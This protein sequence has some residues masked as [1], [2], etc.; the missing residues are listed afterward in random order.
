M[1]PQDYWGIFFMLVLFGAIIALSVYYYIGST[2]AFIIIMICIVVFYIGVFVARPSKHFELNK[3]L[4]WIF[5]NAAPIIATVGVAIT[6]LI[7]GSPVMKRLV[8]SGIAVVACWLIL[9]PNFLRREFGR[10]INTKLD[11]GLNPPWTDIVYGIIGVVLFIGALVMQH[12]LVDNAA[13]E[14][15]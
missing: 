1:T 6:L 12:Y 10:L 11:T 15:E 4:S 14:S 8:I 3:Y 9:L 5:G 13:P 7:L 2:L